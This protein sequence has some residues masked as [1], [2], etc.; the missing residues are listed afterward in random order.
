MLCLP[1]AHLGK[2]NNAHQASIAWMP[3][4]HQVIESLKLADN[5][6]EIA[7]KA[8]NGKEVAEKFERLCFSGLH[9]IA[10]YFADLMRGAGQQPTPK[11]DV[12][13]M[14]V[15][16]LEGCNRNQTRTRPVHI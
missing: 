7:D 9:I 1:E 14:Y 15:V 10:C 16:G 13:R 6:K 4:I 2:E 5:G 11:Q 12:S 8:D 3:R